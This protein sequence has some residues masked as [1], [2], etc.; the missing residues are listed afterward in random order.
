M[1]TGERTELE[2]DENTGLEFED[3]VR[4][5]ADKATLWSFISD[6]EALAECIPGAETVDRVSERKY[7]C[8]I[9]RGIS[10][11]TISIDG[12]LEMVEMNEPDW[13][14]AEGSAFDSKTG[15]RFDVLAAMEMQP[16]DERVTNLS[17]T[18][19]LR[20]TGGISTLPG[21]V[22]RTAVKSDVD[23]YFENIKTRIESDAD[24]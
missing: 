10:R 11:M 12:E 1:E 13:I 8:T 24:G 18:A 17:Y 4:I 6:P 16:I 3:T 22:V 7:T 15:S 9:T 5:G 14:L 19:D 2:E 20:Y 21:R 23:T